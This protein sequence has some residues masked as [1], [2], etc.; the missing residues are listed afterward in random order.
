MK[1][2]IWINSGRSN[3]LRLENAVLEVCLQTYVVQPLLA[4]Y[5]TNGAKLRFKKK[6]TEKNVFQFRDFEVLL[7][8]I[9]NYTQ[10]IS[11]T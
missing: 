11:H 5:S 3:E 4:T 2:S 10:N 8:Y 6:S 9:P 1:D 7:V